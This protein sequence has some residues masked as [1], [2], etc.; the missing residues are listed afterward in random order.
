[1]LYA[2]IWLLSTPW[3]WNENW[4]YVLLKDASKV[5]KSD[6]KK[7][8]CIYH[9]T[10][11]YLLFNYLGEHF[12]T[13]LLFI[14]FWNN[15]QKTNINKHHHYLLY[16][17]EKNMH[18]PLRDQTYNLFS[19]NAVQSESSQTIYGKLFVYSF[20]PYQPCHLIIYT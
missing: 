15:L 11:T 20:Y 6:R 4:E 19:V 3:H 13:F 5:K 14:M 17:T 12:S 10:N 8:T 9:M 7:F 1:M 16:K 18:L 2:N